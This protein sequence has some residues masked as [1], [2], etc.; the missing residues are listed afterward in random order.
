MLYKVGKSKDLHTHLPFIYV[1]VN[2][3]SKFTPLKE[4]KWVLGCNHFYINL[5]KY[6]LRWILH[7]M[8]ILF[9][10]TD[11]G[12]AS[13]YCLKVKIR[14]LGF[15]FSHVIDE[16]KYSYLYFRIIALSTFCWSAVWNSNANLP[17]LE[18]LK[19][20]MQKLWMRFASNTM[21][22]MV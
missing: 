20:S 5:K 11:W 21:H 6:E 8:L 4:M 3:T 13:V 7:L 9:T 12:F 19:I 2:F 22:V 14:S 15:Q 18:I 10:V 17:N 16:Y 1:L